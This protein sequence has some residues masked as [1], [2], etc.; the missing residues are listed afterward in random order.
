MNQVAQR[1]RWHS[2]ES[3]ICPSHRAVRGC[4]GDRVGV[5][6]S[7]PQQTRGELVGV[8]RL[9]LPR[10]GHTIGSALTRFLTVVSVVMLVAGCG[11]GGGHQNVRVDQPAGLGLAL[12]YASACAQESGVCTTVPAGPVP[13]ALDR[14]IRL[15][16][17][18][19]GQRCPATPGRPVSNSYFGGVALVARGPVRPLLATAGDTRAG[20]ADLNPAQTP[21]WR[22]FKTLW[23]S[24]PAYQ[25]PFVIRAMRLDRAGPVRL[26]G[27]GQLPTSAGPLLVPPGP[28]LNSSDGFRTVPS[29]TWAKA[30]G[31]YGFQV[32][33]LTFTE[34]LVVHAEWFRSRS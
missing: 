19:P 27:S 5:R 15:R 24:M 8:H 32:D 33:G 23:F 2:T 7:S 20:I 22:E 1:P 12:T 16:R 4:A 21:G 29:G 17:L 6:S 3:T 31:C 26:S 34:T 9:T 10:G 13:T 11:G 18:R 28:T 25:G 14:P 30:P